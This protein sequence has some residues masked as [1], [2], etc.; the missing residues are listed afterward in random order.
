M[1]VTFSVLRPLTEEA[2]SCAM[3]R[4]APDSRPPESPESMTAAVAAV[5]SSAKSES[6]GRTSWTCAPLTPS[7]CW[8]VRAISPSRARW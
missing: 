5:S 1:I 4:T 8:T 3:P 7:T 6:S 2:V